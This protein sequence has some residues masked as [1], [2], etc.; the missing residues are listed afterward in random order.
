MESNLYLLTVWVV[1]GMGQPFT[2]SNEWKISSV[3]GYSFQE[4]LNKRTRWENW[5]KDL[6]ESADYY[7]RYWTVDFHSLFSACKQCKGWMSHFTDNCFF[8][9]GSIIKHNLMPCEIWTAILMTLFA[10][11]TKLSLFSVRSEHIFLSTLLK[12][13]GRNHEWSPNWPF[14][15]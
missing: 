6:R 9:G 11:H 7:L 3:M 15:T 4:W 10:R 8:C 12:S 5:W 13:G 1:T 14:R 2:K